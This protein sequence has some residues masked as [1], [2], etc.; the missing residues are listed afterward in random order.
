VAS[1]GF[2]ISHARVLLGIAHDPH[3]CR[4]QIEA[5]LPLPEPGTRVPAISEA[6]ALLL[7]N[8]DGHEGPPGFAAAGRARGTD[9]P[10]HGR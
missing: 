5:H 2:L 3:D 7:G 6:L 4:Y 10:G 8:T 1:W 9:G